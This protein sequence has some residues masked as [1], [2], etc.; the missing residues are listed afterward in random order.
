[1]N[2]A[3]SPEVALSM[4]GPAHKNAVRDF[5]VHQGLTAVSWG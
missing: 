5:I 1:M 2:L 4:C 3:Y